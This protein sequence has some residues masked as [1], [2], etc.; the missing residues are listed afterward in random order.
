MIL[1]LYRKI[2]GRKLYLDCNNEHVI[3]IKEYLTANRRR[4]LYKAK[5]FAKSNNYNYVWVR[6][7]DILIKK[8]ESSKVIHINSFTD[9]SSIEE[10]TERVAGSE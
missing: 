10:T 5:L 7:G 2:P 3:Y 6:N 8:D 9:F 1:A 4:L